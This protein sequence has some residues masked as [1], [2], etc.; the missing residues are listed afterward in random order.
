MD[1]L[2]RGIRINHGYVETRLMHK[3]RTYVKTFG[4]DSALGRNLA[5]IYLAEKRKEILMGTFGIHKELPSKT[6]AEVTK[7]YYD[8]WT[9][10]IAPDGTRE[11]NDNA[12]YNLNLIITRSL[13]PF[14][15]KFRFDE[16]KPKH[17]IQWR[18]A[19]TREVMGT[20]VNREQA[21]LSSLFN[22]INQWVKNEQIKGFKVPSENPCDTVEKAPTVKREVVLSLS[23]LSNVRLACTSRGDQALWEFVKLA[24]ITMLSMADLLRLRPGAIVNIRRTKTDNQVVLPIEIKT[25]PNMTNLKKRWEAVRTDA[26]LEHVQM[27]DLRK[28]GAQLMKGGNWS[29]KIISDALGHSST[30]TTEIYLLRDVEHLKQPMKELSAIVEAI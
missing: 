6:F 5:S 18:E 15:S 20:S 4:P 17:V 13:N 14:F 19:R 8:R 25:I 30:R 9:K 1:N 2:P 21:V 27:R 26:K 10:M 29:T 11:H 7:I 12:A 22:L 24:V 3:G 16:I 28:T 23:D